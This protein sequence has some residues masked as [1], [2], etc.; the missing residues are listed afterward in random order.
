MI[1]LLIAII[2]YALS[3]YE[4]DRFNVP[5]T[6]WGYVLNY[7]FVSIPTLWIGDAI[8]SYYGYDILEGIM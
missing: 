1:F 3:M 8:A 4:R 2:A 7:F 6:L 5:M